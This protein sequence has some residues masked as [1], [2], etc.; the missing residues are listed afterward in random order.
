MPDNE[1]AMTAGQVARREGMFSALGQRRFRLLW[2][3]GVGQSIGL[4]M[5]QIT[6]GYYVFDL[7]RSG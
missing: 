4:G 1:E 3:S 5:Q 2:W 6:L 7:T